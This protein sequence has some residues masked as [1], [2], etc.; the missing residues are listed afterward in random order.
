MTSGASKSEMMDNLRVLLNDV[1]RLHDKGAAYSKLAHAQ[2]VVDGYM[3]FL[4]DAGIC[5]QREL[6][7]LVKEQRCLVDGPAVA[8][9]E[10]DSTVVAA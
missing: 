2:G 7:G 4:L 3:R 1:L 8:V 9:I 6:L 10:Q 5:S